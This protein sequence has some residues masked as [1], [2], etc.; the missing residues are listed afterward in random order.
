MHLNFADI[1]AI[2]S[3]GLKEND[4]IGC[5]VVYIDSEDFLVKLCL[6]KTSPHYLEND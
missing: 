3:S 5:S 4:L 2:G 6:V 1:I